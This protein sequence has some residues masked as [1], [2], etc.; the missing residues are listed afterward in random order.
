[1]SDNTNEA[2]ERLRSQ[3]LESF[4]RK[5]ET[6]QQLSRLLGTAQWTS[7]YHARLH[8]L[9][10]DLSSSAGTV[11]MSVLS[12][13][14]R[15]LEQA[16]LSLTPE[17]SPPSQA[18]VEQIREDLLH[19][20]QVIP[21][22]LSSHT[23]A[24]RPQKPVRAAAQPLLYLLESDTEQAA[25]IAALLKGADY[26]VKH[27]S[28]LAAFQRSGVGDE[29]PAAVIMDMD[30]PKSDGAGS[31]AIQAL[32]KECLQC[33]PAVFLSENDDIQARLAA[34][35]AGACR[36]LVKP[37]PDEKL[38][39]VVGKISLRVPAEPYRVLLVD[40]EPALLE[41][42][43]QILRQAGMEVHAESQPLKAL[44]AVR[45]FQPEVL[46]LD[47]SMPEVSGPEL[48]ALLREE[49]ENAALP[50]LF[51]ST[52]DDSGRQRQALNLAGDDYLVKPVE[53]PTSLPP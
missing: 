48:A 44:E 1:M 4:P 15:E 24:R 43:A 26:R 53:P 35:R 50:I 31:A 21:S 32:R 20:E 18:V 12:H 51:L 47:V 23:A 36:Y 14:T 16:I 38:L 25:A 22:V 40:D 46:L 45:R 11:G 17:E 3:L 5:L 7:E 9:V 19:L 52:E 10:H 29:A 8:R 33:P 37:V 42:Q 39:E 27:F 30:F 41:E 6:I 28:S 13:A 2:M 49:E 34:Y